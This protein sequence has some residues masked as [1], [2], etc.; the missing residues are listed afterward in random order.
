MPEEVSPARGDGRYP[1]ILK[2]LACVPLQLLDNWGLTPLI[3]GQRRDFLEMV[4]DRRGRASTIITSQLPVQNSTD[5]PWHP[6]P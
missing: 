1:R 2:S 4:D 3:V 5:R 6:S